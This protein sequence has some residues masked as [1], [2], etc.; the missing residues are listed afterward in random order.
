MNKN[1]VGLCLGTTALSH[2]NMTTTVSDPSVLEP[3]MGS[4]LLPFLDGL[5]F[6]FAAP[7]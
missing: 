4:S 5:C 3:Q 2:R 7:M 6:E 1:G